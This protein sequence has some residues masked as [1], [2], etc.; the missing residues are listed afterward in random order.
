MTD[1]RKEL[2]AEAVAAR[3]QNY[4]PYSGIAVGAAL[5]G[6]SDATFGGANIEN[7]SYSAGI[8]AERAAFTR[9]LFAGERE[10]KAIAVTG[11]PAG[12]AAREYF[13]PCGTCRQWMAEF[14]GPDFI[15]LVAK[16]VDDFQELPLYWLQPYCFGPG[17]LK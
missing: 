14:C 3:K 11:G 9:A 6:A 8:C 12:E 16:D 10:F 1:W 17:H 7:A 15:V 4:A 13:Y 5:L 2:I